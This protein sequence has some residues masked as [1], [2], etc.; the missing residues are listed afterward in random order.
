MLNAEGRREQ[1][2]HTLQLQDKVHVS[3]L[4][5]RFGVSAVTIRG[6]LRTLADAGLLQRHHGGARPSA[7]M[8]AEAPLAARHAVHRERKHDIAAIAVTLIQPGDKLILDAGSTT[9]QLARRLAAS[10]LAP[11]SVYT[12]SLPIAGELAAVAELELILAGGTLRQASQSLQGAHAE[13][14]LGSYIFDKLFLGADGIDAAFGL[15]THDEAE[16]RLNARMCAQARQVIVLADG[17]KFGRTCLHRICGLERIATIISDAS[18]PAPMRSAL[19]ERGIP[20]LI[21]E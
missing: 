12:N 14:S 6:D 10:G 2:L 21:A 8:P 13:A 19:S 15:S 11:L 18:L 16:A 7:E 1:I 4:A 17:S 5:R 20:L 3:R 9:L